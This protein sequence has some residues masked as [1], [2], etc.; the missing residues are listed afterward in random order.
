MAISH[1]E[2]TTLT[3]AEARRITAE[4]RHALDNA[5]EW[6]N[7]A[8]DLIREAYAGNADE[9]LGCKPE[10]DPV[11]GVRLTSWDVYCRDNFGAVRG[12]RI[13]LLTR[14]ALVQEFVHEV[15][16]S[17]REAAAVFRVGHKTVRED[18]ARDLVGPSAAL[19]VVG[20][21]VASTPAPLAAAPKPLTKPQQL[22]VDLLA[23]GPKGLTSVQVGRL[24]K[25]WTAPWAVASEV[26]AQHRV[27]DGVRVGRRIERLSVLEPTGTRLHSGK[28]YAVYV[29]PEHVAGRQV[30]GPGRRSRAAV[31]A[32]Q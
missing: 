28:P 8:F 5:V 7:E 13:P 11:T 29:H 27:A 26:H 4:A 32:P 31:P 3:E 14:A 6:A 25:D 22:E 30:E 15:G 17:T 19:T 2:R 21:V 18:L 23:A 10:V 1:D 12:L 24:H 9:A 16:M 20:E